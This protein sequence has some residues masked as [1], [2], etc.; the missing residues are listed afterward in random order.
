MLKGIGVFGAIT[1]SAHYYNNTETVQ[2]MDTPFVYNRFYPQSHISKELFRWGAGV[3]I[4]LSRRERV[5]WQTELEYCNKGAQEKELLN[6]FTGARSDTW[7]KNKYSY[8]Q[9]NNYLKFYNPIG[10][11][12]HWYLLLGVRLEYLLRKNTPVFSD[13]S[14]NFPRF[15]FSGDVGL[16]YEFPVYKRFSGFVEF[17]WNPDIIS[18][19]HELTKIRNRT[20]ELRVGAVMRP[21]KRSIDDCNT[22]RYNGPNY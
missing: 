8:L 9:W 22:P 6:A 19:T 14:S 3:F 2:K 16:G 13:V 18:H 11:N 10:Y 5:R 20:F 1:Q 15:W 7:Q 4:E 21:R 17:H 12:A